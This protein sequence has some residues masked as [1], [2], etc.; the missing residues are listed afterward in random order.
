MFYLEYPWWEFIVRAA[1]VFLFIFLLFRL[2]GK[3][4]LGEMS[5]FDLVLLLI[6]GESVAG[7]LIGEDS[8]LL[9]ALISSTTLVGISYLNDFLVYK[10]ETA[11]KFLEGEP[12][13]VVKNGKV[14]QK[15]LDDAKITLRELQKALR[16]RDIENVSDVKFAILE[17]NGHITAIKK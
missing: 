6:V 13:F 1:A 10:S 14:I 17:T 3:K 8:S 2:I 16:E 4:Q 5:P 7:A 12:K 11:E 9:G 15:A